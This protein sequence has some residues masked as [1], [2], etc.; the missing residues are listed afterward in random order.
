MKK[1]V[2]VYNADSGLF[3]LVTDIAHKVLS[4]NT[5]QCHLC[6]LAYGYFEIRET[7]AEFLR[8][9]PF[10]SE[11]LHRDEFKSRFPEMDIALPAVC[12]LEAEKLELCLDA[13]SIN[14]CKDL[15]ELQSLVLQQCAAATDQAS[16]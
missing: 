11:F 2:F 13:A 16:V 14:A 4:P 5:Y 15:P 9:A 8:S 7:W 3:N 10:E 6:Q 12:V 1:L